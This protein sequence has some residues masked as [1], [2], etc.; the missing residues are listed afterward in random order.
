MTH[1][2]DTTSEFPYPDAVTDGVSFPSLFPRTAEEW[3]GI[4]AALS[5]SSMKR[6]RK[7]TLAS[8]SK[9]ASKAGIDVARYEVKPDGTVVV[10][11]G[12]P[13]PVEPENP[14]PLDEFRTKETK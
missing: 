6:P 8:V 4:F 14:W 9:Q 11:A 7:P 3:D 12:K 10:V 5:M 13:A 2:K 1:P